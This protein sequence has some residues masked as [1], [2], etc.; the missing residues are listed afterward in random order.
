MPSVEES[1]RSGRNQMK[2]RSLGYWKVDERRQTDSSVQWRKVFHKVNSNTG[3]N[4]GGGV[5]GTA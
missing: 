2:N 3:L 5:C 1:T 4:G